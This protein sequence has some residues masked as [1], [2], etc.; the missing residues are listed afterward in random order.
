MDKEILS[1]FSIPDTE[2]GAEMLVGDRG[3]LSIDVEVIGQIEGC[4]IF[5]KHNKAK[6]EG[7]FRPENAKQ[8]RERLVEKEYSSSDDDN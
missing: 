5:R 8:M 2:L 4:T 7:N 6:A 3:R 1:E